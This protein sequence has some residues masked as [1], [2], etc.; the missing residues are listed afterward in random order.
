MKRTLL[1][2][3]MNTIVLL[4][5]VQGQ[6]QA[7]SSVPSPVAL[8]PVPVS[9]QM[10]P[11]HFTLPQSILIEAPDRIE[12]GQTLEELRN[13]LSIPTGAVVSISKKP[14]PAATVR[15][16][17]AKA[18]NDGLG[19]EGYSLS[20][21]QKNITISAAQPAGLF[22]GVQTLL[23]LFPKEIE[24]REVMKG[25]SW[26]APCVTIMDHP[27]FSW[28]GLMLDVSRHFFT[29]DEVKSFIDGMVRYKYNL[30][31]MHLT[32]DEGWRVE[33]KSLPNLTK[34][35]A[36]NVRRTGTFGSFQ[37]PAPDEPRD[38]GG[39]YT[40]DDIRE[41]VKYA[42][43]R[44]VDILPEIDC[45]GHSLAAIASY[46]E[47]SCTEGAQNYQVNSGEKVMIWPK[48][49]R[50][51]GLVDNTLCPAN[52]K[53]YP[54]LDKVFTELASLFPFGY[55]HV[56]GDECARNFW[57]KSDAVKQLMQKEGLKN[58]DEVQS[59]FEKRV[60]KIV[61]SKGK[62]V[63]GW[64]EI[65]EGGLAP[66]ALVMSWRGI[67]GG[68]QAAKMGHEVVM[69]PTTFAYLDYMQG[70]AVI[71]PPVYA[72]LRLKTA[73]SFEPVPDSVDARLIKGGQANLWTE[74]V[75]N[76]RHLQYM[77][78]PRALAIAE[79][80]WSPKDKK[81][82]N[83]FVKRTEVNFGRM[84]LEQVKYARSMFDATFT[85]K[86]DSSVAGGDSLRIELSTEVE[87]LNIHYSFDNSNPDNFYSKY[88][89][90]LSVP[91]EAVM[92]KVITYRDGRPIGRQLD[93]PIKELRRR[94]GLWTG[95]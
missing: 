93:M 12:L 21:T 89:T 9:L 57:E 92:L 30:L 87:G 84:D 17:L 39:F 5:F 49:G 51:Y 19:A 40:Q 90:P 46:P 69:S 54:F 48:V 13:R 67:K 68:I 23:Q 6:T 62:K 83:D 45:P 65:L 94:A 10:D 52:E 86:K 14:A 43:D 29:K 64:D 50:F 22:Y 55:I 73:Y 56:G 74:Q 1:V 80:L 33:I 42:K 16:V 36:W 20:V 38:N 2:F 41:L 37:S 24:G 88:S 78:W 35:G 72:T 15:L 31:H 79:C 82:W 70:D 28:R 75:Y 11:G 26:E 60:E 76:T 59:Y 3:L 66:N 27:R 47:L 91:K 4:T 8:I 63:I 18:G 44:F 7:Q 34:K 61:E 85:P 77:I 58:L 71:E 32:D 95:E 81:D 25:V 53:V